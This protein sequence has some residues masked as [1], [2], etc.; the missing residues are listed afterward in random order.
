MLKVKLLSETPKKN[1]DSVIWD[2][3]TSGKIGM[4]I[5]LKATSG[6]VLFS[7]LNHAFSCSIRASR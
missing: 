6:L 7:F 5:R 1:Y 2:Y 3:L 4:Y